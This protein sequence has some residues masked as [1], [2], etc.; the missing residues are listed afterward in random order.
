MRGG[1]LAALRRYGIYVYIEI[2]TLIYI[3]IYECTYTVY[4]LSWPLLGSSLETGEE[5]RRDW[6]RCSRGPRVNNGV[7]DAVVHAGRG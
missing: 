7:G 3:Y 6:R 2:E 1:V 5:Q 4:I